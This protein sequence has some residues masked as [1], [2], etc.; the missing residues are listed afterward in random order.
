MG[1]SWGSPQ[2][3]QD[4]IIS[5]ERFLQEE[6]DAQLT[7]QKCPHLRHV[8]KYHF[9]QKKIE[10]ECFPDFTKLKSLEELSLNNELENKDLKEIFKQLIEG[11]YELHKNNFIGRCLTLNCITYEK[12]TNKLNYGSYGFFHSADQLQFPPECLYKMINTYE[13]D[14]WSIAKIM[15]QIYT[16]TN[17]YYGKSILE[18][19]KDLLAYKIEAQMININKEPTELVQLI[20]K[21][22]P[23]Y[24]GQRMTI[25]ELLEQKYLDFDQQKRE[26]MKNFYKT[27]QFE[28]YFL[29]LMKKTHLRDPQ[30]IFVYYI[31]LDNP[32]CQEYRKEI[33]QILLT[34]IALQLS[35]HYP[36]ND[37]K[38]KDRYQKLVSTLSKYLTISSKIL[39]DKLVLQEKGFLQ[40]RD[41][42]LK[43]RDE[44]VKSHDL[45]YK[46][47]KFVIKEWLINFQELKG[48]DD[49]EILK[50]ISF[51]L[52]QFRAQA[53]MPKSVSQRVL[54]NL[55]GNLK[56][57]EDTMKDFN[58]GNLEGN[59][60]KFLEKMKSI[61]DELQK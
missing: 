26:Q 25:D 52:Y 4:N 43:F 18:L 50:I 10:F 41:A 20:N 36:N 48:Y 54:L 29:K 7:P 33:F 27:Y 21:L 31:D 34:Y 17:D 59:L 3:V 14:F 16:K 60:L 8:I 45:A 46:F 47:E 49:E 57:S 11:L 35:F 13:S 30:K 24:C 22:L 15:W 37:E 40:N 42:F 2:K 1:Q 55:L 5:N 9:N 38:K 32:I 53:A 28:H 39:K 61:G 44:I 6:V 19:G 58:S 56:V 51:K 23:V 12:Q